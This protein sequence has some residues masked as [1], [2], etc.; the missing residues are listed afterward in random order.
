MTKK[1]NYRQVN[2]SLAPKFI[3]FFFLFLL[4]LTTA[5]LISAR[6]DMPK[7]YLNHFFID[8]DSATYKAIK[9]SDF[10]KNEFAVFEERTT[11]ANNDEFWTGVY[12][13][14]EETY[15]E[16]FD[17]AKELTPSDIKSGAAFSVDHKGEFQIVQQKLKEYLNAPFAM[18]TRKIDGKQVPWFRMVS[19]FYGEADR[20]IITWVME[21][22]EDYLRTVFPDLTSDSTGITRREYHR[23]NAA[24]IATPEQ[25]ERKILKNV[26]EIHWSLTE[27]D[28][29]KLLGELKVFN[30]KIIQEGGQTICLGPDI[31]FIVNKLHEGK[32]GITAIKMSLRHDNYKRKT[33]RF[34]EKMQLTLHDDKTATWKFR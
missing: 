28:A 26:I 10:I 23:I 34:G 31:K 9:E 16:F 17:E 2:K 11:V 24:K 32:G 1:Q 12:L 15:F 29:E 8:I 18:R 4:I 21:Y 30:Y 25:I 22:H 13:Y 5:E 27:A 19:V 7:V 3:W 6:D 20:D 33:Y 14:G